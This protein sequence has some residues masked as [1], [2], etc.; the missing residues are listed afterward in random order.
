MKKKDNYLLTNKDESSSE[1]FVVVL[2]CASRPGLWF[3]IEPIV[4]VDQFYKVNVNIW[5]KFLP[6]NEYY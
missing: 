5:A 2:W 4:N 1:T 6:D 3:S